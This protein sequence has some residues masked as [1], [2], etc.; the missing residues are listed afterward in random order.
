MCLRLKNARYC[1]WWPARITN[2]G[3]VCVGEEHGPSREGQGRDRDGR[4]LV[5]IDI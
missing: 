1:P 5:W 3:E 2:G 4:D